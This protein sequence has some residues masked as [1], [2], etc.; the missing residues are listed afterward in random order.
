M[1]TNV[2]ADK[3]LRR[4]RKAEAEIER[5]YEVIASAIGDT[6]KHYQASGDEDLDA[7]TQRAARDMCRRLSDDAGARAL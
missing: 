2:I 5:L 6:I 7:L 3:P 1:Q 4:S